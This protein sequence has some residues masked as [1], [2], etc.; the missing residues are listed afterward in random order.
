MTEIIHSRYFLAVFISEIVP[1]TIP[2][3][4]LLKS[5]LPPPPPEASGFYDSSLN[6]AGG[7]CNIGGILL[8]I[9]PFYTEEISRETNRLSHQ[10]I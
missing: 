5:R 8:Y 3:I 7:Q 4:K 6:L 1:K 2:S 9:M 10:N